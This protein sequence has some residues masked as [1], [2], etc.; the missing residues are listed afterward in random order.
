MSH[1][2]TRKGYTLH[3]QPM[4]QIHSHI[5]YKAYYKPSKLHRYFTALKQT[6][7]TETQ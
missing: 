5:A 2:L 3:S 7:L 6:L 4:T 1:S